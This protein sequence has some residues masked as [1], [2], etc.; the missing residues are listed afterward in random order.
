MIS[1]NHN[2]YSNIILK[3]IVLIKYI[4]EIDD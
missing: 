4:M 3:I 2:L 1:I